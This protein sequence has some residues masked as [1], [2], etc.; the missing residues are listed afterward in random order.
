V[1][2]QF[3][4]LVFPTPHTWALS[5]HSDPTVVLVPQLTIGYPRQFQELVL[6]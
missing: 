6:F 3:S 5:N 4:S 2:V 1:S